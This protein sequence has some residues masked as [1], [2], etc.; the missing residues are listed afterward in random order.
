MNKKLTKIIIVL[1]AILLVIGGVVGVFI[2][3]KNSR[4][5][6][7]L[8]NGVDIIGISDEQKNEIF[9]ELAIP[10]KDYIT[11]NTMNYLTSSDR[12]EIKVNISIPADKQAEFNKLILEKYNTL[13]DE[14]ASISPTDDTYI[15]TYKTENA[16]YSVFAYTGDDKCIYQ[17]VSPDNIG[18]IGDTAKQIAKD[19]V[20]K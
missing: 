19:K 1:L 20:S 2:Y 13:E 15:A 6:K 17:F 7:A 16:T 11:V 8:E 5:N 10:D 18:D 14:S 3:T 4:I 9:N 12:T